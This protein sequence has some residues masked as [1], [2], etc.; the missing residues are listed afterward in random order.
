MIPLRDIKINKLKHG[1]YV[2]STPI[3]NLGDIT[4]RA[5]DVLKNVDYLA[6]EDT[7][8][9]RK[10][11]NYYEISA[12]LISYNN[13]NENTK[14]FKLIDKLNNNKNIG[15]VSDAG[16]PCI[17][18]PGYRLV[19][20]CHMNNIN[21]ISIPGPSSVISSL[22]ISGLP[23]DNFYFYGFLPRKKGRK[24]KF[25]LLTEISAT[26]VIFESP[27]RIVRTLKDI[28]NYMG[29]RVVSVCKEITKIYERVFFG[30]IIDIINILE[31][32]NKLKGEFVILISKEGY[33]IKW[34]Y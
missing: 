3:G 17:S 20:A 26:I 13:I 9:T 23:T 14:S 15:L 18:D 30:N 31:K 25:E 33:E 16:T 4:L 6:C 11:L 22:S 10:L 5:L 32:E 1:L 27:F 7:R 12:K 8:V 2:V 24:T 29:N 34:V 21:V 19:N 28:Y